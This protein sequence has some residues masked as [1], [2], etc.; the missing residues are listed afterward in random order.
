[1]FFFFSGKCK[2]CNQILRPV[3]VSDS[4]FKNLQEC[5]LSNVMIGKNIF[6][7]SSPQEFND[8]K[9]YI[10]MT[11]PYDV[12]VDGLNLAYAYRQ[13]IANNSLVSTK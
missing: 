1:M 11:A 13:K 12:V 10:E 4:E 8:F 5:F 2:N 9:D 3:E 7:N 6:N